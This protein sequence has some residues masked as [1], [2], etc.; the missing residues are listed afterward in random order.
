VLDQQ[1]VQQ[2]PPRQ[3][4]LVQLVPSVALPTPQL[5]PVQVAFLQTSEVGGQL[6]QLPPLPPQALALLPLWQVFPEMQ[7]VQQPPARHLPFVQE[8][9]SALIG[10]AQTPLVQV[11]PV[12]HSERQLMQFPPAAPQ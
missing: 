12:L 3:V 1:P 7:P 8:V 5:P 6:L 11:E 9:P 2:E 4:P 10:S